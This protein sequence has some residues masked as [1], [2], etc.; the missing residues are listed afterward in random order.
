MFI[1]IKPNSDGSHATRFGGSISDG[2]AAVPADIVLPDTFP[3]VNIETA[4]VTHPAVVRKVTENL[5]GETVEKEIVIRP[6]YTQLE[7]VSMTEGEQIP[8]EPPEVVAEPTTDEVLN[9]L[10]GVGE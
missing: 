1:Y 6:E 8:V 10:L 7:V 5:D 3:Y 4:M 2:W 9:T